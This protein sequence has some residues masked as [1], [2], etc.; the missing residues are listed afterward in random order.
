MSRMTADMKEKL[1]QAKDW[2]DQP[3]LLV[4]DEKF[5]AAMEYLCYVYK[6]VD[7]REVKSQ[8]VSIMEPVMGKDWLN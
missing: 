8:I 4:T 2:L 6:T 1:E 3:G 7:D 5:K